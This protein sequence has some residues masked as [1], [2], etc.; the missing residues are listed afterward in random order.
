VDRYQGHCEEA[1]GNLDAAVDFY[2]RGL[3]LDEAMG[4]HPFVAH[5]LMDLGQLLLRKGGAENIRTARH[6]IACAHGLATKLGM[7][8]VLKSIRDLS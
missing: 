5:G 4:S 7:Q 1:M 3:R 8:G 2:Q 6:H